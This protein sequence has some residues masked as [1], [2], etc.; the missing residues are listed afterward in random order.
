VQVLLDD[1]SVVAILG[2]EGGDRRRD[3][4]GPG[5]TI[6][7]DGKTACSSTQTKIEMPIRITTEV[8]V[9]RIR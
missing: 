5:I 7:G 3:A 2:V 4:F 1:R 6:A 9:R 8:P